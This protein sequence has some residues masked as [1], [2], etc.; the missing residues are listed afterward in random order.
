MKLP[1][2]NLKRFNVE[3]RWTENVIVATVQGYE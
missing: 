1:F 3:F 2:S